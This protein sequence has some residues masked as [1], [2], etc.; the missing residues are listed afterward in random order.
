MGAPFLLSPFGGFRLDLDLAVETCTDWLGETH[1]TI[2]VQN[3]NDITVFF[4]S[5]DIDS[6][7]DDSAKL[8]DA[9]IQFQMSAS[10]VS[11]VYGG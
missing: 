4:Q 2:R 1:N 8:T 7:K 11:S 6:I 10:K 5:V 3:N 9:M